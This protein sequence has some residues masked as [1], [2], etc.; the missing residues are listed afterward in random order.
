MTLSPKLEPE[1]D[2]ICRIVLDGLYIF[3]HNNVQQR[4]MAQRIPRERL[5]EVGMAVDI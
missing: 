2:W 5:R 1:N 3:M 4:T